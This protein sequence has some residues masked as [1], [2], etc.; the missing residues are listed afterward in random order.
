M[1]CR[2]FS[3]RVIPV[4]ALLLSIFAACP[5]WAAEAVVPLEKA[6]SHNDYLRA[7]PLF[8]ALDAGF[9]SV[10][11]DIFLVNGELLVAHHPEEVKPGMTLQKMYLDPLLDRVRKNQGKVYPNGPVVTLLI[12]FKTKPED[13]WPKLREVLDQY[14][15]MLTVFKN[16]AVEPRAVSVIL[17]GDSPRAQLQAEPARLAAIDGRLADIEAAPSPYLVPLISENWP[18]AFKWFGKGAMPEPE[19]A[20]LRDLVNKAHAHG[21]RIRFYGTPQSPAFWDELYDAGIDLLNGDIP[22]KLR[23]YLL[24]KQHLKK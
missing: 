4:T 17:T 10:E 22:L 1:K 16:D 15:E 8:D 19:R 14:K 24:A 7:H 13:T 11:A 20:K 5:A 3:D 23:D 2:F 12:D 18:V 21:Q 6:H 9:C